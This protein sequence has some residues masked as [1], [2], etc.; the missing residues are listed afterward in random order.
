M[1]ERPRAQ[2]G[3]S[4]VEVCLVILV[5]TIALVVFYSFI[6]SSVSFRFKSGADTFGHG[7]LYGNK[8]FREQ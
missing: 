5:V 8:L 7:L 2:A 3:Q 6:Q 4:I 1:N